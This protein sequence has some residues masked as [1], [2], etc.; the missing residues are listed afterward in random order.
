MKQIKIIWK[1]VKF[2]TLDN[3]KNSEIY[4]INK[5]NFK[6]YI[7]N[8][9]NFAFNNRECLPDPASQST[10]TKIGGVRVIIGKT[11]RRCNKQIQEDCKL[12][13]HQKQVHFPSVFQGKH[14]K[15]QE[16]K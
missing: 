3:N 8:H 1:W 5:I 4:N 2:K 16:V 11:E 10:Q 14:E 7:P 15:F 12:I 6:A 9:D 13:P